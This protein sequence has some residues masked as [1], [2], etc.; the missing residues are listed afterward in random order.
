MSDFLVELGKNPSLKKLVSSLGL[1]IPM[2]QALRR[3]KGPWEA[4]PLANRTAVV[5]APTTGPVIAA[6]ATALARSGA[7][8]WF[9]G[10]GAAR[11]AFRGPGEAWGRPPRVLALDDEPLP[12]SLR[13]DVL[14]FD[15]TA[16]RD[17]AELRALYDFFHPLARAVA[18]CA[19]VTVLGRPPED[20]SSAARA[21][22]QAALE[23]FV[24]SLAKELGR[25][26]ATAQLLYVAD[27]AEDRLEGPLRFFLSDHAAYIS[28]QPLRIT[29]QAA[30]TAE[31]PRFTFPLEGKVALVTGAARGI[32]ADT[33]RRLAAEGARVICLDRPADDGPTSQLAR[34]IGGSVLL[35][36]ITDPDAPHRLA[37]VAAG[38]RGGL[39]IIVHNAG[40][41]RDKTLARMSP[42]AWEQAIAV[43]LA[44]VV[45][46]TAALLE[47]PLND[48][49]RV[50]CLSSIAGL[51]GNVGQTNYAAS[52][53]GLVGLVRHLAA[54]T[55][56]RGI[57]VN[58]LAP[59]FIETRLTMAMPATL[60]EVARRM[61]SLGQGGVPRDIAE[62]ITFLA[63]PGA[64]GVTGQVLRVCGQSMVGA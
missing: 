26:G 10:E 30:P 55:A 45:Q 50:V 20:Q 2:P 6:V 27:G 47:G 36:D 33:A 24:R 64:Q 18:A 53:A 15:A 41:T 51:A 14:V 42:E 3:A 34:E 60:R 13:P 49:G 23:G 38:Q 62:A 8:S 21:A 1:P 46:S 4:H 19:R 7:D 16:L 44:A 31:E 25:R 63:S 61:N 57:T 22:A 40:V 59:G 39:D 56:P 32:G 12:E 17:P 54:E 48:G 52:K 28:G 29:S 35:L 43:N 11:D 5:G 58:A 9:V 37:E